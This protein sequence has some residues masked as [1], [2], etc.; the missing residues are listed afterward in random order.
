MLTAIPKKYEFDWASLVAITFLLAFGLIAIFSLSLETERDGFSNFQ[1]QIVFLLIAIGF[2]VL[3][4]MIDYRVW[5]SYS[6]L[7]YMVGVLLLIAVLF[8]GVN[9]RGTTG[10][11]NLGIFNIQP[12]ELMKLFLIISLSKYFSQLRNGISPKHI[13]VSL[14]YVLVPVTLVILQ[15]DMGSAV[16]MIIIWI[17]L[18]FFAGLKKKYLWS[19][20]ILGLLVSVMAWGMIL[21]DYQKTRIIT[22]I[23]PNGDP[24]GSGYNVIQSIVAIGSGGISGKGLGHGSQSQLNFLPEKHTDFIYAAIAEESGMIGTGLI[25]T[26]FWV[27]L[28]RMNKT[29]EMSKD[30]FGRLIVG[31]VIVMIFFQA[32]I[33]IGM[34]LGIMPV[35]GLSLPLLSYGGSFLIVTMAS[36]GLVQS[37][38]KRRIKRR[39]LIDEALA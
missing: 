35:A 33:N 36:L 32:F 2:F 18:L 17:G 28:F 38:W 39:L 12:A 19:I 22:F 8:F 4:S 23:D 20:M 10:W 16:V 21:K 37:V 3:F 9:I 15:P 1:K 24:L 6:G 11:F 14:V 26:L 5:K 27:L 34:N 31:G 30:F 7:L 13:M 25:L 29:V